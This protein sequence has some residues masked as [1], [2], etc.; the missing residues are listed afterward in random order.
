MVYSLLI[1]S[2]QSSIKKN[3]SAKLKP[4][5]LFNIDK[6]VVVL[7]PILGVLRHCKETPTYFFA[8]IIGLGGRPP[9]PIF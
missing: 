5:D 1:A 8:D 3:M 6:K 9:N 4:P 2:Y 7:S